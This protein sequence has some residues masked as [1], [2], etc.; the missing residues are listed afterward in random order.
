[1]SSKATIAEAEEDKQKTTHKKRSIKGISDGITKHLDHHFIILK[2]LTKVFM[3][4][5][6]QQRFVAPK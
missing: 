4:E 6:V 1:L 3:V 2:L 5:K